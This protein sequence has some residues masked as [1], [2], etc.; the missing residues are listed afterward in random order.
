MNKPLKFRLIYAEL[1]ESCSELLSRDEVRELALALY[2]ASEHE[3]IEPFIA[4]DNH[5]RPFIELPLYEVMAQYGW[6]VVEEECAFDD[7]YQPSIP[8]EQLLSY[9]LAVAA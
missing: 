6:R 7:S 4:Q 5:R 2:E 3:P 1:V 8:P 9:T